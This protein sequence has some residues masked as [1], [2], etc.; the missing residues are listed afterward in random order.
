VPADEAAVVVAEVEGLLGRHGAHRPVVLE[1]RLQKLMWENLGVVRSE[2]T[3]QAAAAGIRELAAQA[4]DLRVGAHR[5]HNQ[6]LLD[7]LE[8]RLMLRTAEMV[9]G[10]ALRRP[11]S[12]GA[13]VRS[14]YPER[15][16]RWLANI[17][18]RRGDGGMAF[19][20]EPVDVARA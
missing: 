15:D 1:R 6:E 2:E 20:L 14:D 5:S 10:S 16:D 9:A 11:E 19:A 17:V 7:A 13:H 18:V 4:G 8:L 3:I 12:R